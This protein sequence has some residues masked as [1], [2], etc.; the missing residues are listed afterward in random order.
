MKIVGL[1]NWYEEHPSWLAECVASASR[2]CDHLIAVDGAYAA[3]PGALKKPFSNSDQ[4]DAIMRTAAGAGMGV[5]IHQ[6]R[7]PWWG[8]KWGGEV[9]KRDFMFRLGETFTT[10]EDWYLRIDADEIL[11]H[12]PLG[13]REALAA[14][15]QNVAE[16]TLWEREASGHIGEVVDSVNDYQQVF[17]CLF[18]AL[19]GIKIEQTH[20]TVIAGDKTLNGL[21]QVPALPLWDVRLEHR[22]RLRTKARKRLKDEYN[23]LIND[24]ERVDD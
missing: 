13:T 2:L 22:T 7:E 6:S 14:T 21:H 19:P 12:V 23:V 4:T 24:F 8:T 20:F 9:E 1:L 18:R 3:F 16:V 15:E 5:T 11:T 17:R 10:P